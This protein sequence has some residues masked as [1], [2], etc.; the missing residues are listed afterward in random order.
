[1]GAKM[2]P[3][4]NNWA[5]GS[6]Q[7]TI[8]GGLASCSG[9]RGSGQAARGH[10][11]TDRRGAETVYLSFNQP[12][13][14]GSLGQVGGVRLSQQASIPESQLKTLSQASFSHRIHRIHP[15]H[16]IHAPPPA[17]STTTFLLLG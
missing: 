13:V 1:M 6:E 3:I 10:S 5:P 17:S 4:L 9:S 15:N 7:F 12:T 2:M 8:L 16:A 11:L 14:R